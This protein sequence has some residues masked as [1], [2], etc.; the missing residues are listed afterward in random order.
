[1]APSFPGQHAAATTTISSG[2]GVAPTVIDLSSSLCSGSII[3]ISSDDNDVTSRPRS[4][5]QRPG[6]LPSPPPSPLPSSR[7]PSQRHDAGT[8]SISSDSGGS[9]GGPSIV[10]GSSDSGDEAT[11]KG[12][13]TLEDEREIL[14]TIAYLRNVYGGVTPPTRDILSEHR[15]TG[16]LHR[17]G[18]SVRALCKKIGDLKNQIATSAKKAAANGGKLRRRTKYRNKVLYMESDDVWP[19]LFTDAGASYREAKAV[20]RRRR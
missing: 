1:M 3:D 10:D 18:T 15:R 12:R 4:S 7:F 19:E 20:R 2:S 9:S 16:F 13:W 11:S 17:R 5:A 6:R 14:A 8:I